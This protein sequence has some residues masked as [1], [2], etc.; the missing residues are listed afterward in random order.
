MAIKVFLMDDH[1]VVRR[2]L[3]DLISSDP[4]MQVVGEAG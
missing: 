3:H 1:E 4:E 2:G